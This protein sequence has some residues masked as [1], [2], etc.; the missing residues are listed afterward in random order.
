[1]EQVMDIGAGAGCQTKNICKKVTRGEEMSPRTDRQ[2]WTSQHKPQAAHWN[3]D[4]FFEGKTNLDLCLLLLHCPHLL[5]LVKKEAASS[6]K[7]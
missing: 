1:M 3:Q 2:S 4:A 6:S 7:F 5:A